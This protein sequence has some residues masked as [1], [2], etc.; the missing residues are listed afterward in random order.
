MNM[1]LGTYISKKGNLVLYSRHDGGGE[2]YIE[3]DDVAEVILWLASFQRLH[4]LDGDNMDKEAF[5]KLLVQWASKDVYINQLTW[6]EGDALAEY[7]AKWY[8]DQKIVNQTN[9]ESGEKPK[10]VDVYPRDSGYPE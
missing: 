7:L 6:E 1:N 2:V 4:A 3:K 5:R 10:Y 9:K 8:A